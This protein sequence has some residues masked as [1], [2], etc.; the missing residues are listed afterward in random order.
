[1]DGAA[2]ADVIAGLVGV[3]IFLGVSLGLG[4]PFPRPR[5]PLR[6]RAETFWHIVRIGAPASAS[7]MARPLSTFVLLRVVAS[8]GTT[9]LAAIGIAMRAISL[10][11]IPYSGL[12]VA[13]KALVGQNLGARDVPAAER[14]VARGV[15]VGV[16]LAVGLCV[17]YGCFAEDF[18]GLF[19]RDPA[20]IASGALCVQLLA[21]GLLFS[22]S[23]VPLVA[24]MNGA[25]DTRPPMVSTVLAN[26]AFKL[27]LCWALAVPLGWGPTGVWIGLLASLVAEAAMM[28]WWFRR[29]AWRTRRV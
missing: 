15:R 16:V 19:D 9:A 13:V 28:A 29:S 14:V 6:L 12:D 7:L 5:E 24:T 20:V 2:I 27:P 8:F 1:V 25:G 3:C 10:N 22:G 17:F 18:V 11:W 4:R 26:W 21:A 23:A